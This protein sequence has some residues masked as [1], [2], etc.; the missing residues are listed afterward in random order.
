MTIYFKTNKQ[1]KEVTLE[2]LANIEEKG[3]GYRDMLNEYFILQE[4][5]YDVVKG[6]AFTGGDMAQLMEFREQRRKGGG[7]LFCIEELEHLYKKGSL[8]FYVN[9]KG[10]YKEIQDQE[11][12]SKLKNEKLN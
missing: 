9:E 10:W 11:E 5:K 1:T 3:Q 6:L 4:S 2:T 8:V 7:R 12:F